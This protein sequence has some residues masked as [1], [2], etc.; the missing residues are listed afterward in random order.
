MLNVG[1]RWRVKSVFNQ[2][3]STFGLGWGFTIRWI[4]NGQQQIAVEFDEEC[5]F[6]QG[7]GCSGEVPSKRGFWLYTNLIEEWCVP[8]CQ[9]DTSPAW[10]I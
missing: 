7:H 3:G 8:E 4:G 6:P 10:T 5:Q 1:D 9:W 2:S